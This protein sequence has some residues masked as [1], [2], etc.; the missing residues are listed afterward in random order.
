MSHFCSDC[1]TEVAINLCDIL[2]LIVLNVFM[3]THS[4]FSYNYV[5]SCNKICETRD[6]PSN[7][8]KY[9]YYRVKYGY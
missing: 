9:N 7:K 5:Q 3:S 8:H 2:Y 4:I 6:I 1:V